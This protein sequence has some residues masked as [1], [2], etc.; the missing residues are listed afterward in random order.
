MGEGGGVK[1]WVEW[2]ESSCL[3]RDACLQLCEMMKRIA[4]LVRVESWIDFWKDN[5]GKGWQEV[6]QIPILLELMLDHVTIG[7]QT[8]YKGKQEGGGLKSKQV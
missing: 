2:N 1:K 5:I 7:D 4:F 8:S 6:V 3:R